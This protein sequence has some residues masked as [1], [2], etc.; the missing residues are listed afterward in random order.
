MENIK[1]DEGG[2]REGTAMLAGSTERYQQVD[3]KIQIDDERL[4]GGGGA[5]GRRKAPNRQ[6]EELAS[7][8]E[9]SVEMASIVLEDTQATCSVKKMMQDSYRNLM[10]HEGEEDG[11][12]H[13]A[14]RHERNSYE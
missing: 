6:R 8:N 3:H 10:Y 9:N 11:A 12:D 7:S 13:S 5:R 14:N 2:H 4:R 1:P